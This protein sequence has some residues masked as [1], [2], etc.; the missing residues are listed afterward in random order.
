MG[1]A[2]WLLCVLAWRRQRAAA[3]ASHRHT[4][5]ILAAFPTCP[6]VGLAVYSHTPGTLSTVASSG[7]ALGFTKTG[8]LYD[9]PRHAQP[10]RAPTHRNDEADLAQPMP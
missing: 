6:P 9:Q 8:R 1:E 3:A 5:S 10:Q 4:R 7:N 2:H